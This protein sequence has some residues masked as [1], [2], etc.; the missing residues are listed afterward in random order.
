MEATTFIRTKLNRPRVVS[1][2]VERPRLVEKLN[3]GLERKLTLVAAPAGFGKTTLVSSWLDR[4]DRPTAWLSLDEHDSDFVVFVCYLL[5]AI[6]DIYENALQSTQALMNGSSLPASNLLVAT[7]INDIADLPG[8]LVL[9]LDDYH[10]ILDDAILHLVDRL[11]TSQ[12]A[13]LHLVIIARADP[14]LPLPRLRVRQQM[15]EIRA[16][17]LRFGGDEAELFL[18]MVVGN[19]VDHQMAIALNRRAEGW[20]AG[21]RLAALSIQGEDDPAA[22]LTSYQ[23]SRFVTEYLVSEVLMHQPDEMREFLLR[24]AILDR[25]CADLC[26]VVTQQPAGSSAKRL[27]ELERANLFLTPLDETKDW[28]RYHNLFQ[29]ML[30]IRLSADADAVDTDDL[31]RR[32]SRWFAQHGY[33]EEALRHALA[34]DDLSLAA[35][36]LEQNSDNLLNRLARHTLEQWLSLL[37]EEVIWQRP[38][39][40]IFKAW[41]LYR[42]YRITALE[43]LLD[44]AEAGL[45]RGHYNLPHEQHQD[46][47]E[48]I[49]TFRSAT[50]YL[51]GDDRRSL[52]AAERALAWLPENEQDARGL[53][54][55]FFG[56][57]LQALGEEDV[58][59]QR[60]NEVIH[61]PSGLGPAKAQAFLGLSFLQLITGKL[62]EMR[63]TTHQFRVFAAQTQHPN[64]IGAANYVSG[65]L[66]YELDELEVA[67][68]Y[69]S[70]VVEIQHSTNFMAA[71]SCLLGLAR[72]HQ[73][74]GELER[75]QEIV[76]ALQAETMRLQSTDLLPQLEAFQAQQWALQ[77]EVERALHW[78]RG[79]SPK[80]APEP[81]LLFEIPSLSRARIL[82]AYGNDDDLQALQHDLEQGLAMAEARHCLQRVIQI[83][84]HLALVHDGLERKDEALVT[85][86]RAV[87]LARPGGFIRSFVDTGPS[88][89]PLL[90]Q[91]ERQD[92]LSGYLRQLT[93][94]F[95]VHAAVGTKTALGPTQ[96]SSEVER[97]AL[98]TL[99]EEEVLHLIAAGYTNQE[100]A[101]ELFISMHT[102]KRH[103][104]HIYSKLGV[105]NR[106]QAVHKAREMGILSPA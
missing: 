4:V 55:A 53:A 24:T 41:Q 59:V 29:D 77:G 23:D 62:Q 76:V 102:V 79:F 87:V 67:R 90:K 105:A 64:V 54:L 99:R 13:Q 22:L 101:S 27:E 85:L 50:Y 40:L 9:V 15:T 74:G 14:L 93:A 5:H 31:H 92:A 2:L 26:D 45:D 63:Q 16:Q 52:E 21:L 33:I 61:D 18:Q 38:H 57:A 58:A 42:Q 19:R 82:T 84:A 75:S 3:S 47:R 20:I 96:T 71:S 104:T 56:I 35:D 34:A 1:D 73:L 103:A 25:F 32:A 6:Q 17:D 106:R 100:I 10:H 44:Q 78:A 65:F 39:L 88:L 51:I 70:R 11:V 28:Y 7:L 91:I 66:H 69:F 60:Y 49:Q 46:F 80:G 98:L 48:R 8:P 86:Q 83:L 94:A 36:T 12:P 95:D 72:I 43:A 89:L 81:P 37:P 30:R 97:L 68:E